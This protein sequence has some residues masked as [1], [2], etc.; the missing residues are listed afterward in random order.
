[1]AYIFTAIFGMS[2]MLIAN[3]AFFLPGVAITDAQAVPKMAEMLG[4]I[5]GPFGV[6]R[7]LGRVLG[8]GVRVAPR[9]LAERAVSLRG[10]LRHLEGPRPATAREAVTQVT[11]TP[12]RMALIFITL[13]PLP[14]RLHGQPHPVIVIY[15]IVGSMFVPFLAATLL[16]LNNRVAWTE[17]VPR[18]HWTTNLLLVVI[19]ALFVFVGAQEVLARLR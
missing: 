8:G 15:T 13:V 10:P 5:L 14:L 3:R 18:N 6:L 2:I 17:P 1:M 16:Y 7:L 11:S 12:Y 9:R 4:S 19:L